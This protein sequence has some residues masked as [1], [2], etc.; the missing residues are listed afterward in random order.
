MKLTKFQT[1]LGFGFLIVILIAVFDITAMNSLIFGT[2]S[3]YVTGNYTSG[4]WT[5]FSYIAMTLIIL[6]GALY[7]FVINK[8]ISETIA[9]MLVPLLLWRMFG[10]ADILFF[11]LQGIPVPSTLPWLSGQPFIFFANLVGSKVVT[12]VSLYI[13]TAIGIAVTLYSAKILKNRF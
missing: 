10:L 5:L 13:Q 6:L 7:Y 8:D 12:N 9:V 2:P 4:W 1:M 11:W 3:D